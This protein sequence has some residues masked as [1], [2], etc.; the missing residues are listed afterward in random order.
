MPFTIITKNVPLPG[1]EQIR[2][3]DVE[4][5]VLRI[6][7]GTDNE[8]HLEDHSVQLHHAVIQEVSGAYVLRDLNAVSMTT[9]NGNRAKE[10]ILT[11]KGIIRIGP[12]T[13]RFSRPFPKAPLCIE[14]EPPG[15]AMP[16]ST[17][18]AGG[19]TLTLPA[20]PVARKSERDPDAT[21][22]IQ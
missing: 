12:Y 9:V 21:L 8:L 15:N 10:A 19:A 22:A 17:T 1:Q 5:L 20:S 14:Y 16:M 13:L 18:I 6:G 4:G 3:K 11:G 7:R 2:T